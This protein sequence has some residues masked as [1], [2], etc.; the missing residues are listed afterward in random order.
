MAMLPTRFVV[1]V[2]IASVIVFLI[3]KAFQTPNKR[4]SSKQHVPIVSYWLPFI[5]HAL[6]LAFQPDKLL[7]GTRDASAHGVFAIVLGGSAHNMIFAPSL[8]QS[9]FS[10]RPNTIDFEAI[11]WWILQ[12][13][14][15]IPRR[16]KPNFDAAIEQLNM[17]VKSNLLREP[18]LGRITRVTVQNIEANA[19]SLVSFARSPLDRHAWE[20]S[21]SIEV[22]RRD[23]GVLEAE[24]DLLPLIIDFIGLQ[25]LPSIFGSDFTR[26]N[27]N[28]LTGLWEFNLGFLYLAAGLPRWIPI[29]TLSRA[30]AARHRVVGAITTLQEEL[31]ALVEDRD[32]GDGWDN[33]KDVSPLLRQRH[34]IYRQHGIP[35]HIRAPGDLAILWAQNANSNFAIFWLLLRILAQPGLT[36]RIR[37]EVAPHVRV[38]DPT[39]SFVNGGSASPLD[40]DDKS[41][42]SSCPLL[43]AC[44]I[45]SMRMDSAPWSVR[46]ALKDFTVTEDDTDVQR[47]TRPR[48]FLLEK[49][50]YVSV[51]FDLH[52]TDPKY[53]PEP[54]AFRPERHLRPN[55]DGAGKAESQAVADRPSQVAEWGTV[56]PFGGGKTMCKGRLFAEREVL[57][58]V[59]ALLTL[60][61]FQP[62]NDRK[63]WRIPK[64]GKAT[65]VNMPKENVRVR[66]RRR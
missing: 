34:L 19:S 40:I 53:F 66:I 15:G 49:G 46:T 42:T 28:I 32:V 36:D 30:Y 51:P 13:V 22:M 43:K 21:A 23:A 58:C 59:A 39:T 7:R 14:G 60:W 47:G 31:D 16:W 25:A 5:G 52:F 38:N 29:P 9:V 11:V 6:Q 18:E 57:T 26:N 10:Q 62:A 17:A 8:A 64:H 33:L 48:T 12:K 4:S 2:C 1:G 3:F 37:D 35:P 56:R 50:S 65:G 54:A 61:D 27:P 45:E 55:I 63:E 24:V 41:L 44:F 20:K